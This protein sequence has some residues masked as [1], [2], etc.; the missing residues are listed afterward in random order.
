MTCIFAVCAASADARIA[1]ITKSRTPAVDGMKKP[2]TENWTM[3]SG[4]MRTPDAA[5]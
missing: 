4:Q 2:M 3:Q 1:S 5:A